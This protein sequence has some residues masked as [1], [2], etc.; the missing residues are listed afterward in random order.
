MSDSKLKRMAIALK[1]LNPDDDFEEILT[2]LGLSTQDVMGFLESLALDFQ[3]SIL[4]FAEVDE[5]KT[6][7]FSPWEQAFLTKEARDFLLSA[8]YTEAIAPSEMEQALAVL[9]ATSPEFA[10]VEEICGILENIVEDPSRVAVLGYSD[11][12]FNH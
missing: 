1:V 12:R 8:L 7:V 6:R 9:F 5:T 10:D 4:T 11:Q 3:V 2:N